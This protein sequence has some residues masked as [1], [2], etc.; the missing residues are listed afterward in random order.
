MGNFMEGLRADIVDGICMFKPKTLK[1]VIS[2]AR[3]KD[4][5]LGCQCKVP[6]LLT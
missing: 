1:E 2:L 6:H 5:Q 4:K 3:M